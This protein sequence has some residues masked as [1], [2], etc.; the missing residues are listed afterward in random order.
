MKAPPESEKALT[1]RPRI[2][3]ID[4]DAEL[5]DLVKRYLESEG[6]AVSVAH[7]GKQG[8]RAG[9]SGEYDLIV[10]DVMLP[11]IK[12]FEVLAEMRQR[13]RTPVLMLTAKGD[14]I[15]RVLGLEIGADDYLHKPFNPRELLA[16]I[17]AILRRSRWR[18]EDNG[19]PNVRSI[20]SGDIELDL[21]G[22]SIA[23]SGKAVHLTSAEFDLLCIFLESPGKV[24]SR[25]NLAERVLD[26][27]FAPF[28]R[29]IDLH[30]SNLRRK[31]GPNA[32]GTERI[33]SVRG[34]GYLY[35]WPL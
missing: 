27:E 11:D 7:S 2:L 25:E 10:L 8:I 32:D 22:H 21:A 14:E 30:V 16:R 34:I 15:D 17:T 13:K 5:C 12:G 19:K 24:L 18:S 6:F 35:A 20:R 33:R 9:L 1:G 3:I 28:D 4:D 26:R 31:L 23:K 29:S